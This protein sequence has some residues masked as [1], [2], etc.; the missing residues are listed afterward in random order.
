MRCTVAIKK[1]KS[2]VRA[3]VGIRKERRL[4]VVSLFAG[5]GGLDIAFCKTDCVGQLF[6]TDS[7]PVFLQTTINN[8]PKYFPNVR[9]THLATNALLL[10]GATIHQFIGPDVDLV[11]GGPPCDNFT[12]FG[13]REGLSGD[14]SGLIFEFA[15]LVSE[16]RPSCFVFE[17][18]PNL[19]RQFKNALTMLLSFFEEAGYDIS[20]SSL[21]NSHEYGSPTQRKRLFVIGFKDH[22]LAQ[23]FKFPEATHGEQRSDLFGENKHLKPFS[24]VGEALHG[25]PDVDSNNLTKFL[26]HTGRSHRPLTVEHMKTVPQGVAVSKSFRYRAPWNGLCRSLTAGMDDSTKSYLHP[27]YHREMSVR[28]YARLH[29]FPDGWEFCGNHHNGIKQVANAVP[30]H[31]GEA[32][33]RAVCQLI[34][35]NKR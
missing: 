34:A 8:I 27:I 22:G 35:K 15:R 16:I 7:N 29:G 2:A 1:S 19:Q 24:T 30:I 10:T 17:N 9:H 18:V 20:N 33:A 4:K 13:Q 21:Q 23:Q 6:S 31:L 32:V 28:E 3:R 14:K 11:I 12:C 5:A 26:N 25:L